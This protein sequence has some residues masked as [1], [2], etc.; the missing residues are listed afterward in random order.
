MVTAHLAGA[1]RD[2]R[3]GAPEPAEIAGVLLR[4][5]DWRSRVV[6]ALSLEHLGATE[7]ID[8]GHVLRA[9]HGNAW[10]LCTTSDPALA[11][12]AATCFRGTAAGPILLLDSP[13]WGI[14]RALEDAGVPTISYGAVGDHIMAARRDGHL[15]K[16]SL[17]RFHAEITAFAGLVDQLLVLPRTA[18]ATALTHG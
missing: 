4:H 16:V 15:D 17:D 9:G 5:P 11:E 3:T 18:P 8:D 14:P 6:A 13:I 10:N 12:L 7:W 1:L 2:P